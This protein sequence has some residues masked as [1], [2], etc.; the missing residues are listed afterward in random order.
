MPGMTE[1]EACKWMQK[2]PGLNVYIGVNSVCLYIEGQ[3]FKSESFILAV[4]QAI[5]AGF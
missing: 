4:M 5:E 3:K 2:C 1:L